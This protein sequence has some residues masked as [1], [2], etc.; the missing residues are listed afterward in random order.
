MSSFFMM[1]KL[2]LLSKF[3]N[4]CVMFLLKKNQM[5]FLVFLILFVFYS[6]KQF[7]K[8]VSK[9]ALYSLFPFR[10]VFLKA[11]V[12]YNNFL[13]EINIHFINCKTRNG[14]HMMSDV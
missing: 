5:C 3:S 14:I 1:I 4:F 7:K 10:F 9:H 12:V 6:I 2:F 8:T 11:F 13:K